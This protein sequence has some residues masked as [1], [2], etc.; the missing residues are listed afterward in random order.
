MLILK[1][2][3]G[4]YMGYVPTTNYGFQKP[5]KTNAFNVDDLNNA[6]DK[7][8]ET[9]KKIDYIATGVVF[10]ANLPIGSTYSVTNESEI[11]VSQGP[12]VNPLSLT[13]SKGKYSLIL[14]I[15]GSQITYKF[16]VVELPY[17]D[18]LTSV[19]CKI[20]FHNLFPGVEIL[21]GGKTVATSDSQD[22]ELTVPKDTYEASFKYPQLYGNGVNVLSFDSTS[23][24]AKISTVEVEVVRK[25]VMNLITSNVPGF[26]VPLTG[27]YHIVAIG[28][29]G[30]S[31]EVAGGGGSGEIAD[32]DVQLN[33][34]STYPVTIGAGANPTESA[35]GITSFG[36]LVSVAGGSTATDGNGASGGAGGGGGGD[37]SANGGNGSFGGGGGGGDTDNGG[38]GGDGGT[39]GGGGGGG[40]SYNRGVGSGGAKGTYG[41]NGGHGGGGYPTE[42]EAKNGGA[43]TNTSGMDLP[44]TGAGTG[45]SAYRTS[46]QSGGGGGG[47]YGGIGGN[48]SS[49]G[50]GGGGG[51]FGANGGNGSNCGGG[52]GGYGGSGGAGGSYGGGGGGG[53]GKTPASSRNDSLHGYSGQ[54]YGSGAGGSSNRYD[55]KIPLGGTNGC[56]VIWIKV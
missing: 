51:G 18:D 26:T 55:S 36:A 53:Y 56:L 13:L 3:R 37:S 32:Q 19:L 16:E 31:N 11:S 8:D 34:G 38:D 25:S 41:G 52:G 48:G 5:E 50:G 14:N 17:D 1:L 43:G 42:Y 28:G 2:T 4:M 9:I 20:V 23:V 24:N 46:G 49:S 15:M 39:Y 29:G 40:G 21:L 6:L 7:I 45:G 54:G 12:W 30:G 27:T 35:G 10:K 22:Y 44:F 33:A 47:G